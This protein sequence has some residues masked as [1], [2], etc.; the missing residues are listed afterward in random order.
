[1]REVL[2]NDS[3]SDLPGL[4]SRQ[5]DLGILS[6]PYCRECHSVLSI[7]HAL[8]CPTRSQSTSKGVESV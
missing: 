1:M 2:V 6:E 7:G 8:D 3:G 4:P 5:P